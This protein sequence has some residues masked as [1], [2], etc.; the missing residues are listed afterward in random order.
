M[1]IKSTFWG[2]CCRENGL[3]WEIVVE[4]M[5]CAGDK[6]NTIAVL[7]PHPCGAI[8]AMQR[9]R[10]SVGSRFWHCGDFRCEHAATHKW[11]G[12]HMDEV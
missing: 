10:G 6:M 1:W 11:G 3:F 12:H 9:A 8:C 7:R 2:S 5:D 4:K